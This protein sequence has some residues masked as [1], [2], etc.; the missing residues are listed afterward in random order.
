[1][2]RFPLL[3]AAMLAPL[4]GGRATAQP[5]PMAVCEQAAAIAEQAHGLP[6]GLLAAIGRIEA[7]RRD[8]SGRLHPWP[9]TIDVEGAGAILPTSE[10]AQA[11]VLRAQSQ[12]QSNIDVGCF[13][14]NLLAHPRAFATLQ[15]AF[16]PARNADYAAGF[17]DSLHQ[18]TGSW[19]TAVMAYHSATPGL[20]EPYRDRVLAS[21]TGDP[22]PLPATPVFLPVTVPGLQIWTPAAA[23]SA[24]SHL[25]FGQPITAGPTITYM[26]N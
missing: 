25:T 12:G 10:A 22:G 20:G 17:L 18:R 5:D 16:D 7:G 9:W 23:G 21:W 19:P 2:P 24:P 13:Q 1:M 8:P 26:K 4:Y 14:V 11:A 3:L 15:D 6:A